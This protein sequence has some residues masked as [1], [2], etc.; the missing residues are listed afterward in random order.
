MDITINSISTTAHGD[1]D[2]EDDE[3]YNNNEDGY[4]AQWDGSRYWVG[5][6]IIGEVS[7][8]APDDPEKFLDENQAEV[9][10]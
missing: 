9:C 5:T 7:E 10:Q 1:E 4:G 3:D 2:D 8:V 6:E